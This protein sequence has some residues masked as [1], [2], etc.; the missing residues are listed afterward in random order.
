MFRAWSFSQRL[1]PSPP[2]SVSNFASPIA[3][4]LRRL[5]DSEGSDG[6]S[7]AEDLPETPLLR[8][9]SSENDACSQMLH[10]LCRDQVGFLFKLA[11][12]LTKHGVHIENAEL[13]TERGLVVNRLWLRAPRESSF[14]E[15]S[16]WC[17]ELAEVV[18]QTSA[19]A[20]LQ[21]SLAAS[22][23][24]LGVNLD[25][26]SVTSLRLLSEDAGEMRYRLELKGI[27]QAGVLAYASFAFFKAGFA[28]S[29]ACISASQGCISNTF[30]IVT[31]SAGAER[32]LRS[33][34]NIQANV[35]SGPSI[36]WDIDCEAARASGGRSLFSGE[37][38]AKAGTAKGKMP[39]NAPTLRVRFENGDVYEGCAVEGEDGAKKRHG[40]GT[41]CYAQ[42]SH[43]TFR[44][45]AGQWEDDKKAGYGILFSRNGAVYV[46][47]WVANRR[48]GL[49]VVFDYAAVDGAQVAQRNAM[50]SYRYEGQWE[51]DRQHGLGLEQGAESAYFGHYHSGVVGGASGSRGLS[52]S[53]R[54]LG[55]SGCRVL[56][57]GEWRPLGEVLADA[58]DAALRGRRSGLSTASKDTISGDT[59]STSINPTPPVQV[60]G[61]T[62][63][64]LSDS[65]NRE[66]TV[67]PTCFEQVWALNVASP[68]DTTEKLL[69]SPSA[70]AAATASTGGG[71]ER[72]S[73]ACRRVGSY[74]A[75]AEEA[76]EAFNPNRERERDRLRLAGEGEA[77]GC[78]LPSDGFSSDEPEL[79]SRRYS[80]PHQTDGP[81]RLG[82]S[83]DIAAQHGAVIRRVSSAAQALCSGSAA[84]PLSGGQWL[85]T[86]P[87]PKPVV[88]SSGRDEE[89]WQKEFE[90]KGGSTARRSRTSDSSRGAPLSSPALWGPDE[91]AV[92]LQCLGVSAEIVD[93]VRSMRPRGVTQVLEM[94]NDA[95]AAE[96]GL[97]T[98]LS[99]LVV[100]RCLQLFLA[101]DHLQ[102]SAR[103][104]SIKDVLSDTVLRA[105]VVPLEELTLL[106]RI[107]QGGYGR[108]YRGLLRT[109]SRRGA[110][111][112][113][114]V[115]EM[116]GERRAELYELLKEARVMAMLRH[117]NINSFI[118]ICADA[119]PLG[120]RYIISELMDCSLSD[121]VH[122]PMNVRWS[123]QLTLR[124]VLR[125]SQGICSGISHIHSLNLVHADLK[126]S[127]ILVDL[128]GA[129]PL[130]RICDFGHAAVRPF[131][132]T[133]HLV[134][135][136]HWAAPEVLRGE[137]LGPKADVF[138]FGVLLWE[139]LSRR[140]PH[141]DLSFAQV[142]GAAGWAGL[143][144]D[145]VF[146]PPEVPEDVRTF[147]SECTGFLP[148]ERPTTV[149]VQG[150][151]R[152]LL[153]RPLLQACS[154]LSGFLGCDADA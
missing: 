109:P 67:T 130:P 146:L 62:R 101:M 110:G 125:I 90:Q 30:E 148:V 6:D 136:P 75:L 12:L 111:R 5:R 15:A 44:Q 145:L 115:K 98:Q 94:T 1:D 153:R 47:Q 26:L 60:G 40:L 69:G 33:F 79:P 143:V 42:D 3:S 25:L 114:A 119:E 89:K 132:A 154:F 135:T 55:V 45:Y 78:Q 52:L 97:E 123:G 151:L 31:T 63:P 122:R 144:P 4:V 73:A 149:V 102:N 100:R 72:S 140:H 88:A 68:D 131:P 14:A 105:H 43:S 58:A 133:H 71:R 86:R 16:Q 106:S 96:L 8:L 32:M 139:M 99:R 85:S 48:H 46:G 147:V 116:L 74:G 117:P 29:R 50:P 118:G 64:L 41:Y 104:L 137:A 56:E 113:V 138:S 23:R 128:S 121:L 107:S 103:G 59:P 150:R 17:R 70:A 2:V 80:E 27:N 19:P 84:T 141:A 112:S 37:A 28:V 95:M 124:L 108:V 49:G 120:K 18:T 38:P 34:L 83:R 66:G 11:E 77:G 93:K 65:S 76:Q 20:D 9:Y 35:E 7:A 51:D 24:R 54:R 126:S 57:G 142:F 129:E 81:G 10:V 36:L 53:F 61:A 21:Q 87:S 152:R 39:D 92:V 127:N 82:G 22:S 91:L 13:Y 134:G